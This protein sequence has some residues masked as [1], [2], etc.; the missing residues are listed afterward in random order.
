MRADSNQL[1]QPHIEFA[2]LDVKPVYPPDEL[3][4]R[5]TQLVFLACHH[6]SVVA[7]FQRRV[8]DTR[9]EK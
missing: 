1:P 7:T 8:N 6:T 3:G 9:Y 2:Q 4:R 5:L